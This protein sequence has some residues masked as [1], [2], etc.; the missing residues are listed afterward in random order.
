[1]FAILKKN[2]PTQAFERA[3]LSAGAR[4]FEVEGPNLKVGGQIFY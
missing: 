1:M 2:W 4:T 3:L